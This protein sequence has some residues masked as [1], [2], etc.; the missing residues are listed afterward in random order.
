MGRKRDEV[1]TS[2]RSVLRLGF[3]L[4]RALFG[5]ACL[6]GL[7]ERMEAARKPNEQD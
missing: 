7:S 4:R 6:I 3:Q 1:M 5:D 2:A